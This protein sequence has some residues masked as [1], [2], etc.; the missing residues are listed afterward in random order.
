MTADVVAL[1]YV[2]MIQWTV[3]TSRAV[4]NSRN[5]TVPVDWYCDAP[6]DAPLTARTFRGILPL[7]TCR[8]V[9]PDPTNPCWAEYPVRIAVDVHPDQPKEAQRYFWRDDG[10][11]FW[12]YLFHSLLGA[13]APRYCEGCGCWLS[14][15]RTPTGKTMRQRL[16]STCR[17]KLHLK[18][19]SPAQRKAM[20]R[21]QFKKRYGKKEE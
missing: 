16:C 8:A 20:W 14:A 21:K 13:D 19:L 3:C 12:Q 2:D 15:G 11:V 4:P 7:P 6:M 1:R 9:Y 17:G 18:K 5:M 10:D